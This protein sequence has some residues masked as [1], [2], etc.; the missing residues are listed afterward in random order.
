M[1]K[2]RRWTIDGLRNDASSLNFPPHR[3]GQAFLY[4]DNLIMLVFTLVEVLCV[5][6]WLTRPRHRGHAIW[7]TETTRGPE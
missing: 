6:S 1:R 2:N 7:A 3:L 5:L 4:F